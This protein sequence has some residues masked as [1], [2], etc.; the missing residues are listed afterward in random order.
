MRHLLIGLVAMAAIG[1][2][3]SCG[4]YAVERNRRRRDI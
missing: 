3:D 1:V 2:V 4:D